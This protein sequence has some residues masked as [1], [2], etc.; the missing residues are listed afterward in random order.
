MAQRQ[1]ELPENIQARQLG[2]MDQRS[3]PANLQLGSFS[4]LE[5]MYPDQSGLLERIP[6][7]TLLVTATGAVRQIHPTYNSTQDV[8]VQTTTGRYVYTLNELLGRV[9]SPSLVF[10]PINEEETMSYAI[11]VQKE[12][13]QVNGGSIRGFISGTDSGTVA[14]TMYGRRLTDKVVDD[15]SIVTTFTASTGGSNTTSTAGT[16]AL[17]GTHTYRI[18]VHCMFADTT[19]AG[20]GLFNVTD[21]VFQSHAGTSIPM[22]GSPA[23]SAGTSNVLSVLEGEFTITGTK[24]FQIS[25]ECVTPASGNALTFGGQGYSGNSA[26]VN[27]AAMPNIFTIIKILLVS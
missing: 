7:K 17:A 27:G 18:T 4:W 24:T 15:N 25:Q 13:N 2:G 16:F 23:G 8:L 21:S 19:S 20:W 26:N 11:I 5:G 9:V 12:A 14:N 3:S 10:P 1:S 6:G 22:V